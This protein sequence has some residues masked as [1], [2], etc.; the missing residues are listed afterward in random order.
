[1]Y[2][3]S[4][5]IPILMNPLK[6]IFGVTSLIASMTMTGSHF[7]GGYGRYGHSS[8]LVTAQFVIPPLHEQL[9][10]LTN[11]RGDQ[12]GAIYLPPHIDMNRHHTGIRYH[13][14]KK[15]E[16][17]ERNGKH[18][19]SENIADCKQM[20]HNI[21]SLSGGG[22]FGA[23]QAGMLSD[24]YEKGQLG[25]PDVVTGI[26][27]GALNAGYLAYAIQSGHV[28]RVRESLQNLTRLWSE[29]KTSH[30]YQRDLFRMFSRWSIYDNSALE[31]TITQVLQELKEWNTPKKRIDIQSLSR[32]SKKN[33]ENKKILPKIPK[34]LIGATNINTQ[35][36][37]VVNFLA[38][39]EH[40]KVDMLM[41][42]T[43]IPI[44]FP[45]RR[46]NG[47]LYL[48]GGMI[49]DE[50]ITEAMDGI[51]QRLN[52]EMENGN[53][54]NNENN[55]KECIDHHFNIVVALA[56]PIE[57]GIRHSSPSSL[58]EYISSIL[59]LLFETFNSQLS[60]FAN[61]PTIHMVVCAPT[62]NSGIQQYSILDFDKGEE[63]IQL[64]KYQYECL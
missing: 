47:S 3:N 39:S 64:G 12:D 32:K 43:S 8:M 44:V 1:M 50:M 29:L 51:Q 48:D 17:N 15:N 27:A 40:D 25:I 62:R 38:L 63:L 53:N 37:D 22:A 6:W 56:H 41:A 42:S 14:N 11:T 46:V 7:R 13:R 18:E 55:G 54:G 36:L 30:V 16:R 58:S 33:T 35:H 20:T 28:S 34:I 2:K 45:P 61:R 21:L 10:S 4:R 57:I 9:D 24:L 49:A 23:I 59:H 26:S 31:Q 19:D 60:E 5:S 52:Y